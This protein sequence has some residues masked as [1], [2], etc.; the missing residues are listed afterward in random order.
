MA[1]QSLEYSRLSL[2]FER[3]PVYDVFIYSRLRAVL[4]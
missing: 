2:E 4:E 1:A 3:L